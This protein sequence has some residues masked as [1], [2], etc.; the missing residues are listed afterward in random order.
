MAGPRSNASK[1][2]KIRNIGIAA[3]IDAGKTTISERFLFY[4]GRIHKTGEVHDGQATMDWMAQERQRGITIT[5]AVTSCPWQGH[6]IHLIDTPGHVD[7]TVE[8]ERS[9]R[10]LDGCVAVFC[11]VGGVE[12]QSETVW[13]QATSYGVPRLAFVNKMDRIG[14]DFARVV[15]EIRRTLHTNAVPIQIPMGAEDRFRGVIDLVEMEASR[16][17]GVHG[18]QQIRE[19]IPAEYKEPAEQAKNVLL[20]ALADHDDEIAEAYL[21]GAPLS[22]EVIEKALR[23]ATIGGHIQPVLVGSALK[24]CGV[25][26]L[27]DAIVAFLPSPADR[28]GVA[29]VRGDRTERRSPDPNAPLTA[30]AFKVAL[31]EGR[32]QVYL[33]IYSG[34]LEAKDEV[35]LPSRKKK[36]RVARLR[37]THANKRERVDRA[38]PGDLILASGLRSVET[39]DTLTA[40]G[41][42]FMLES[43]A[44]KKPVM[45]LVVE[46]KHNRDLDKLKTSLGK[47]ADEDPTVELE[48]D[49]NT[50]QTLLF[51]MGELH[52]EV[53]VDRLGREFGIEVNTGRPSVVYRETIQSEAIGEDIFS[54]VLDEEKGQKLFAQVRTKVAPLPRG[55][56]SSFTDTRTQDNRTLH[57]LSEHALEEMKQGGL[58]ALEAGPID[59]YRVQDVAIQLLEARIEP[60]NTTPIALRVATA[61]SVRK[62]LKAASP[63][64]LAPLMDLEVTVPADMAGTVVGDLSA[65]NARIE[66]VEAESG[67][68]LIRAQVSL[69]KMFGYATLL[70]SLTEGRGVFSM[71]FARFDVSEP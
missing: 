21:A 2:T 43:M 37:K 45:A 3:H 14:A 35:Y 63:A 10:V 42:D 36:E 49:E 67:R 58:E 15:G 61:N 25:L 62:A 59:G 39:G 38:G 31:E 22:K 7:F 18:E 23:R 19:P 53:L 9:L 65:R 48:E 57:P 24:N 41:D 16:F 56:D 54:R 27:L 8:V 71:R 66:H 6:E 51:G 70:R 12:P 64:I 17:E 50:G 1:I 34:T 5:A 29:D 20:E 11:A 40:P 68:G 26:P 30:L 47:L 28:P 44:F 32:R 69:T 60:G 52:L 55:T 4:T 46:P 13:N 33:R